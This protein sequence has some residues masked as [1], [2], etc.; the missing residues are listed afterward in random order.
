MNNDNKINVRAIVEK[1][2]HEH[3]DSDSLEKWIS[4]IKYETEQFNGIISR[5]YAIEEMLPKHSIIFL[6]LNPSDG[7]GLNP[8]FYKDY[9]HPHFK[10]GK[11]TIACLNKDLNRNDLVFAQHDLLFVRETD[12]SIVMRMMRANK[13]FYQKQIKLTMTVLTEAQPI[14]IVAENA[15]LFNIL[16]EGKG[17]NYKRDWNEELGVDF[18]HFN[19]WKEPVPILF[20]GMLS[21]LNN[22]SYYSLRWHMR[23]VL[24]GI[25]Y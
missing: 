17:F 2:V 19:G 8:G 1:Y 4:S 24:R 23:H 9:E 6:G 14:L 20:T 15:E 5:G 16:L 22:G 18:F 11:D 13:D 21:V 3:F 12:H 10:R 7:D 25:A